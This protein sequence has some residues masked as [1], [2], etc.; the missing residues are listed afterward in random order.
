MRYPSFEQATAGWSLDTGGRVLSEGLPESQGLARAAVGRAAER[1]AERQVI[2]SISIEAD[3][4]LA[5]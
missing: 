5:I 4:S 3:G 2:P 1:L